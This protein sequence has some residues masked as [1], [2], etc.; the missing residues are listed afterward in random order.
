LADAIITVLQYFPLLQQVLY[1]LS[2]AF[3]VEANKFLVIYGLGGTIAS[4]YCD[5][6]CWLKAE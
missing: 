2:T 6:C 4:L 3:V 1:Q 5:A